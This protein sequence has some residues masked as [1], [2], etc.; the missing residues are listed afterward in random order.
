MEDAGADGDNAGK[1]DVEVQGECTASNAPPI[2]VLCQTNH[3]LDQFLEGILAFAQDVLG[4]ADAGEE[5]IGGY[6]SEAGSAVSH[7]R[8]RR[9]GSHGGGRRRGNKGQGRK[10]NANKERSGRRNVNY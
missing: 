3:A 7:G 1:D 10:G 2:L 8:G 5:R 6:G 9:H 4:G